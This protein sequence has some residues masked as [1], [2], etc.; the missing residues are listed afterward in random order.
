MDSYES[1][2]SVLS[3]AAPLL[4]SLCTFL[5]IDWGLSSSF[6][7]TCSSRGK[8][9]ATLARNVFAPLVPHCEDSP[10]TACGA[11]PSWVDLPAADDLW[12][13]YLHTGYEDGAHPV[14]LS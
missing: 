11:S 6:T 8:I 4:L 1:Y 14:V 13:T 12:V 3:F 7:T 2:E 9:S 10:I 5:K